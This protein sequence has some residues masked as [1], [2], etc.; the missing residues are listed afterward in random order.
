[1]TY[2]L[3]FDPV[4]QVVAAYIIFIAIFI[5]GFVALFTFAL[6]CVA[7]VRILYRCANRLAVLTSQSER[8]QLA[9][10]SKE[11]MALTAHPY[12][13]RTDYEDVRV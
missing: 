1:M 4:F 2:P 13:E 8:P 10:Q 11:A 3:V 12:H 6:L 7:A 9:P 5:A